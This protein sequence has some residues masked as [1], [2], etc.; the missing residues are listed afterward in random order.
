MTM[1]VSPEAGARIGCQQQFAAVHV[2]AKADGSTDAVLREDWCL[3]WKFGRGATINR[4]CRIA[5]IAQYVEHKKNLC[6]M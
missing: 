4:E 6:E 1:T 3:T 5:E 2:S